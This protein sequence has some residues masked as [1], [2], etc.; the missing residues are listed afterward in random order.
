MEK[1]Y[2]TFGFGTDKAN[3]YTVIEA[4]SLESA[5]EKMIERWGLD[6]A[7]QYS[8]DEWVLDSGNCQDFEEQCRWH[9]IDPGSATQVT[10]AEL[11]GL[12]EIK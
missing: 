11:Y 2:F 9:G 6:W 12:R 4:C 7:F 1:F 10:Q 8:E 3:C 5:R